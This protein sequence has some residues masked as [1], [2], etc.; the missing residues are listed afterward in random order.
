MWVLL[1]KS[2]RGFGHGSGE[3]D[4]VAGMLAFVS[5]VTIWKLQKCKRRFV[6]FVAREFGGQ[7]QNEPQIQDWIRAPFLCIVSWASTCV[8]TLSGL[9]TVVSGVVFG[10]RHVASFLGLSICLFC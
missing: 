2:G 9:K 10:C 7:P 6:F 8:A 3:S 1:L 4:G 5:K